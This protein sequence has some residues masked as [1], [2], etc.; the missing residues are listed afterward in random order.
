MPAVVWV[1][2]SVVVSVGRGLVFGV[3]AEAGC[4]LGAGGEEGGTLVD[5]VRLWVATGVEVVEAEG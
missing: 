2:G 5:A 1:V 4:V 3:E